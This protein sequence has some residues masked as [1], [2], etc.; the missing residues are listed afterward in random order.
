MIIANEKEYAERCLKNGIVGEKPRFTMQILAKYYFHYLGYRNKKIANLLTEHLDKYYPRYSAAKLSWEKSIDKIARDAGKYPLYEIDAVWITK[1][2][3]RTI[4]N[5][6]SED[7]K[8]LAFTLLCLAKLGNAKEAKN[9]SWVNTEIKELLE[10]ANIT[11]TKK[12]GMKLL[13]NLR[14]LGLLEFPKINGNLSNRVTFVD[15]D[16]DQA[17]SISDLRSLGYAYLKYRGEN[18]I[19]CATCGVLIRGSKNGRRKYCS[20][21]KEYKL[22]EGKVITCVDCGEQFMVSPKD[23]RTCRCDDCRAEYRR[24]YFRERNRQKS[25]Q[26]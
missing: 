22:M 21:C 9:N 25:E 15:D 8:K 24:N 23:T 26:G 13:S 17:L 6:D 4:E 12:A 19:Q 16:S 1:N 18:I 7:L 14:G 3:L 11:R 5:I 20:S 10:L 2:E